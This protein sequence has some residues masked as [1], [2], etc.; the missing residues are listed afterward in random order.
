MKEST[1]RELEALLSCKFILQSNLSDIMKR[2][3]KANRDLCEPFILF[4]EQ[5]RIDNEIDRYQRKCT[6][7]MFDIGEIDRKIN[8]FNQ[9]HYP[10]RAA[11]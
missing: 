11:H 4:D 7:C 3:E 8:A 9:I 5:A 2:L 1:L 10:N 6:T